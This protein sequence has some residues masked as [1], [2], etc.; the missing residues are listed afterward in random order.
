MVVVLVKAFTSWLSVCAC[1][2]Y[3][4]VTMLTQSR[5]CTIN[6]LIFPQYMF[7]AI[8]GRDQVYQNILDQGMV[9]GL[10]W[11]SDVTRQESSSSSG[12]R[13]KNKGATLKEL[14]S[15]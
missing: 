1:F 5:M 7:S 10:P 2:S 4:N 9:L 11:G 3:S 6:M 8:L 15:F 14:E 12:R 13:S